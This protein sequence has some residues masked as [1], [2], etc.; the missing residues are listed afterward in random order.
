M[1]SFKE[2]DL[3]KDWL[4]SHVTLPENIPEISVKL[5]K[6]HFSRC[7]RV[8]FCGGDIW[9]EH[10]RHEVLMLMEY[11]SGNDEDDPAPLEDPRW[12]TEIGQEI[13]ETIMYG[14]MHA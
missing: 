9:E 1:V 10:N 2:L 8:H 11:L 4:P 3:P 5:L 13:F 6:C 14:K 12:E 7:L